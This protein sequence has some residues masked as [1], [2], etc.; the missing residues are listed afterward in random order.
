MSLLFS[1]LS[2]GELTLENRIIIAPMCQYSAE[3]GCATSWHRIHLGQLALSGAGLLI[4]EAT[5]VEA[6]G[7][8]TPHDLGLYDDDCEQALAEV[9]RDIRE[10]SNIP[11]GIQLAHAGRKASCDVPWRGGKNLSPEQGGWLTSAPSAVPFSDSDTQPIAL[12]EARIAE[13]K[14]AFVETARRADRLGFDLVEIHAAHGYLLHQFL[15]PLSNK[16]TDSWGGSLENRMRLVLEIYQEVRR[17]FPRHKA[18]G[19]RISATDWAQGG[20]DIEQSIELS[21]ALD[22]LGC[23]YIHVSSGGLSTAQ[24]IK[25]GANYQVPFATAIKKAVKT[26]VIA[27]GLITAAQ[28]AESILQQQEADAVALARAM[29]WDPHWPWHAAAEMGAQI[30]GPKQYW[31]SEPHGVKGIFKS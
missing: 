13:I 19:V 3:Q 10:W 15:S 12:T 25:V 2:L 18:V 17:V 21:K 11:L 29:L 24:Q 14:T 30:Q 7:R 6:E 23:D 27:V 31:R 4:A 20:W 22:A 16:R 28:Q 8:I 26:P 5:A 9:V 1:P